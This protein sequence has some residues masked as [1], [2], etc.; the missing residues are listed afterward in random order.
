MPQA[1]ICAYA[2]TPFGKHRGAL[3]GY[4]ATELGAMAVKELLE[5]AGID[6]ASGVIDQVYMGHVLQTGSGQAPARQAAMNAGL[7]VT[8]PCTTVNKVCGSSLK[9][10]MIAATEIRAGVSR[11]VIAGGMESMSNAPH[12]VRRARRGEEVSYAALESVLVHDGLKDAYTGEAMGNTGETI[13]GEHS[14]SREQSDAFAI[15]S[16]ALANKA[17]DEGWLDKESFPVGGLERDEGIRPDSSM[18]S[19]SGLRTV[20]SDGGQITAGNSSQV[21]DG[22]SAV[23]VA[24]EEAAEEHGLPVLARIIDYATSGVESHRVMSAPIPTVR[25][26]LK[27]NG[28]SM[29]DIDIL[30]H[31]EAFA[32][33][34]CAIQMVLGVS[35]DRFNPHGGAVAIGHPL[36]ATGT[37]CLMTLVNAMERTEGHRGIVTIC[38]GGGNAVAMMVERD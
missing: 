10:A 17:W 15:R 3:S 19:L 2:R 18:D 11:M 27:R 16:H 35:E 23:L 22:A 24:S 7:P 29:D 12:F 34:S 20:F 5:R 26:L 28:M 33:A 31:N 37:R 21:S 38:L 1:V 30:E 32:A 25:N 6:P 8:T 36:G 13:A 4:S 9:A 14:I